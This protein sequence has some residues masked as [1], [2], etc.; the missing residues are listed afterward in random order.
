[1]VEK[2]YWQYIIRYFFIIK[3]NDETSNLMNGM[4]EWYLT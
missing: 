4:E 3:Q 1:M 2:K